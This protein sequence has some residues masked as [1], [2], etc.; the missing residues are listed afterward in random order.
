MFYRTK[1][2]YLSHTCL[3]LHHQMLSK[4]VQ[5][6]TF[7]LLFLNFCILLYILFT[8]TKQTTKKIK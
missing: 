3:A 1:Q 4:S 2:K 8:K 5:I 7:I 6:K